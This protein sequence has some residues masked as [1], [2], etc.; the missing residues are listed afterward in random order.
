VLDAVLLTAPPVGEVIYT[1]I[2]PLDWEPFE[3]AVGYWLEV[4]ADPAFNQMEI[5][6]WGIRD[7]EF[8]IES[9]APARYFWRVAALDQ[10]GLPGTWSTPRDF[11]L[12]IDGTPPFLTVLAPLDGAQVSTPRVELLGAT[13][14]DAVLRLNGAPAAPGSDGAFLRE[15]SLEPGENRLTV[16]ATDPAG[17]TSSRT[18]TVIYRPAQ[19]VGFTLD[20]AM[21]RAGAALA[22]RAAEL[23]V[24]AT[25]T[26]QPG[27]TVVVTDAEGAEL[28][29]TQ[30][31]EG[32]AVA[33]SVPVSE[34]PRD[35]ELRALAPDGS[36]EGRLAFAALRDET[37]PEIVLEL[38]PPRAT[39]AGTVELAGRAGDAQRLEL[40]GAPVPLDAEGRFAVT[41]DLTP[42]LNSFNLSARDA[43]GNVAATQLQTLLDLDPPEIGAVTLTRPQ[44]EAGPIE[45]AVE[46]RDASGLRQAA[47]FVI[48]LDGQEVQGFLRCDDARGVCAASLPPSPGAL[49]LREII[50]EDYAG[51]E[52]YR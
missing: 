8:S 32:G 37:P 9:L 34:V 35:Y 3:G 28:S 5:T 30:V 24:A 33:L 2:A 7:T 39:G 25:T 46:A 45:L 19:A 47:P 21:P 14:T 36:V 42:G 41:I 18:V 6:E 52:A 51:N 49:E 26:A 40:N 50:I 48:A 13:E 10:L 31:A 44:G 15:V 27:A 16:E 1:G 29:R 17:N 12:R 4:A 23:S 20:P 11:T 43:V 22:T 38:P